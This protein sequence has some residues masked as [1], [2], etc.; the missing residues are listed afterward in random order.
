MARINSASYSLL[1]IASIK[2]YYHS[3]GNITT[4]LPVAVLLRVS[5]NSFKNLEINHV[6]PLIIQRKKGKEKN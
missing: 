3:I 5:R 4:F 6:L 1:S 2:A